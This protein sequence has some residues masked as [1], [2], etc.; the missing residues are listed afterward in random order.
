MSECVRHNT[1]TTGHETAQDNTRQSGGS[2]SSG[3]RGSSSS[4]MCT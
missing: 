1:C 2:D 3:T 4:S